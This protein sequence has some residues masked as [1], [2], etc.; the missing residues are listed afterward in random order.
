M[1]RKDPSHRILAVDDEP[2]IVNSIKMGLER[3]GFEVD[4]YTDPVEALA[5]FEASKYS[6][7]IIDIKMPGI[8]GFELYREI[9]RIDRAT[10]VCFCTAHDLEY[11]EPFRKAFPELDSGSFIA[12]PASLNG[13]ITRIEEEIENLD[14]ETVKG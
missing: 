8:N 3:N 9:K 14:A 6:L 13:L 7:C 12:K 5:N 2:D 1:K 10:R 11:R 4:A